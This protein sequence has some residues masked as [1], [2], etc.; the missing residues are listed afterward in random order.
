MLDRGALVMLVLLA[1]VVL[2]AV[3]HRFVHGVAVASHEGPLSMG[4][5]DQHGEIC[6]PPSA[7]GQYT[8]AFDPVVNTTGS[9]MM[10]SAVRLVAADHAR[11]AEVY[12]VPIRNT[13]LMGAQYNW[14]P[15]HDEHSTFEDRVSLPTVLAPHTEMSLLIHLDAT[16]PAEV[17]AVEVSYV[18]QGHP[19]RVRNSTSL[20]IRDRCF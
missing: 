6:L 8:Y 1:L 13:T 20:V 15:D 18:D 2:G 10:I 9:P 19:L 12:L 7:D 11:A 17:P 3:G 5:T 14:P 16:V 4:G